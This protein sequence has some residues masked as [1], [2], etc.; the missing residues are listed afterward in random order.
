MR[1][2]NAVRYNHIFKLLF[3]PRALSYTIAV[4]VIAKSYQADC[5]HQ[6][7]SAAQ[8]RQAQPGRT[9]HLRVR[10]ARC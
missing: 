4:P 10:T 6:A 7:V 1:K 9:R 5:E 8:E 2:Q 3:K